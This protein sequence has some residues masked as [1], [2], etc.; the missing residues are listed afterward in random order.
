MRTL[1]R[2]SGYSASRVGLTSRLPGARPTDHMTDHRYAPRVLFVA[3][4]FGGGMFEITR[5]QAEG[6]ARRGYRVAIAYG[7]RHETPQDIRA[8][9][10]D[11]V[12]LIPIPWVDRSPLS[13]LRAHRALRRAVAGWQPDLMHLMSSFSGIHG[14]LL[15]P[16]VPK[17]YT[18]QAYSFTMR[19]Q[20][21]AK[22][23]IYLIVESFVAGRVS[24]VGACSLS[25]GEQARS[26]PGS[27]GVVVVPNG[28]DELNPGR[29]REQVPRRDPPRVVGIGRPLPQR[30][31]AACAR[32]LSALSGQADVMW[33]G[34]GDERTAGFRALADS[35]LIMTGWVPRSE[36]LRE[37]AASTIYLHW[38]AW[39]GLPLS[40][41]EA[42]AHD[43]IVVAN[44]IGPNREILGPGQ[45]C[46]TEQEAIDLIE[47]ILSDRALMEKLV[48]NQR[49]RRVEYGSDEAVRRWADVYR[50]LLEGSEW[51]AQPVPTRVTDLIGDD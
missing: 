47:R 5:M 29:Q 12:E 50:G 32:I 9:V 21:V 19:D 38:T 26:L 7:R 46:R 25:E 27:R 8:A 45:V 43:V 24:L 35:G 48:S 3:E 23:W 6:L 4:A 18:P 28:I 22:R 20:S 40:V 49:R 13:Q 30:Q 41:L 11:E 16:D 10:D 51:D 14:V 44:D 37:L 1:N 36:I 31:P 2:R 39:D 42:M 33:L 17:V 34:G 15:A